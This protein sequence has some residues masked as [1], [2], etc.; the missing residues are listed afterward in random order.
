MI[1]GLNGLRAIAFLFVFFFH[2]RYFDA[3]WMGVQFFFVLSGFL[4]T[5]I[6]LDMKASLS[7]SQYLKKFY[8]RR[9]LRI[10]PLYY[11]YLI[12][13]GV[14]ATWLISIKYRPGWMELF[15]EQARFAALYIY[16]FYS[17][18]I[19]HKY[20][21]FLT[22]FWSLSVEE[23]FYIFW[24]F[25][26]LLV[27]EKWYRKVFAGL[28]FLGPVFRLGLLF[29][30]T[31][32]G[33]RMFVSSPAEAIYVLPFSHIDAFALGAYISRYSLPKPREQFFLLLGVIPIVGFAAQYFAT[34]E[35]GAL[36]AFGYPLHMPNAYQFIWGYSLLNYF[37]AVTIHVIVTHKLFTRFLEWAPLTYLGRISYGL[38]V[39]HLPVLWFALDIRD[40]GIVKPAMVQPAATAIAFFATLLIASASFYFIEKPF[41][42]LKDR[43]FPLRMEQSPTASRM[44]PRSKWV[45]FFNGRRWEVKA[46]RSSKERGYAFS[47]KDIKSCPLLQ[48]DPRGQYLE[49]LTEPRMRN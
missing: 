24:P 41:L 21:Y 33:I 32:G 47:W 4:I 5:G 10:F 39:Y 40:L 28:V 43:F 18:T 38:Y 20:N 12:A 1:T 48:Q 30:H 31:H 3:G 27:P 9:T 45:M 23:Q 22:H 26:I 42:A 16:D 37:F 36:S 44:P 7:R 46:R 2:A 17:A 35:L 15:V 25:L 49:P 19:F 14:L 8:G 11:F 34:G 13:M 29:L 6:L